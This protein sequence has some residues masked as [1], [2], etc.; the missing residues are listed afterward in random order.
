MS[1]LIKVRRGKYENEDAIENVIYFI[2]QERKYDD[3]SHE[4]IYYNS[5]PMGPISRQGLISEYK[6]VQSAFCGKKRTG[7]KM[8]HEIFMFDAWDCAP[9]GND[10][11]CLTYFADECAKYYY[12]QGFQMVYALHVN[13]KDGYHIH[14]AGN[15]VSY[16]DGRIWKTNKA[17]ITVREAYFNSLFCEIAGRIKPKYN[18]RA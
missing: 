7:K 3:P 11:K 5:I 1:K 4:L 13:W 2:T 18:F 17:E 8:F 9:L 6:R 14:F 16:L 15:A 10:R 12:D